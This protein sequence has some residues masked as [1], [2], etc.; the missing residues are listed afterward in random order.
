MAKLAPPKGAVA[1]KGTGAKADATT[2]KKESSKKAGK[3]TGKPKKG[4]KKDSP[5]GRVF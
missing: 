5:K 1:K 2:A 3:G 4:D